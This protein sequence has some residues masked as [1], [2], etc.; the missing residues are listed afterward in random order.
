MPA[1]G[2]QLWPKFQYQPES[3]N[4]H[5]DSG[6]TNALN[7]AGP[8]GDNLNITSIDTI[9]EFL[10]WDANGRLFDA[11]EGPCNNSQNEIVA[12]VVEVDPDSLSIT[13]AWT[14]PQA[15][16]NLLAYIEMLTETDGIVVSSP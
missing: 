14:P 11:Y 15:N 6:S 9:L 8:L 7:N 4:I 5:L 13:A 2:K 12:P 3:A 1:Q 10:L 16:T